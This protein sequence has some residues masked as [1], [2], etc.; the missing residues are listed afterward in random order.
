MGVLK[1]K[2]IINSDE[3]MSDATVFPADIAYPTETGWIERARQWVVKQIKQI[4]KTSS[5]KE[6]IRTYCRVARSTYLRRNIAQWKERLEKAG[7]L[8]DVS[9]DKIQKQ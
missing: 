7:V 9:V 5:V 3:R 1:G 2:K 4:R 6:K 8:V